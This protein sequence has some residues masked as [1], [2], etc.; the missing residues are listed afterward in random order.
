MLVRTDDEI[1]RVDAVWLGPDGITLPWRWTYAEWATV[2]VT[3]TVLLSL[4]RRLFGLDLDLFSV[5]WSLLGALAVH[6][7]ARRRI[8]ADR[9]VAGV[10]G[11][12]VAE[13]TVPRRPARPVSG[14]VGTAGVRVRDTLPRPASPRNRS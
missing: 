5:G 10:V 3:F 6:R 12:F 13:L 1:Y 14:V 11:L 2:A 9:S 7:A 8:T 4:V